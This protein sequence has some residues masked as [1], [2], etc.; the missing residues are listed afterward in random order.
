MKIFVVN[1]MTPHMHGGAEDLATYLIS[2]LRMAGHE[3]ELLRI[4]FRY[5][6]AECIYSEML[7]CRMMHIG[8]ADLVIALK[9]P[10][11]LIPH[12]KKVLWLV[13]QYRQAYDMWDSGYSNIPASETGH[14]LRSAIRE[15]D[16][17]CFHGVKHLYTISPVTQ[18][19]LKKY[20]NFESELLRT[21]IN[22]PEDYS[23]GDYGDYIFCGGRINLIKRQHL[24]V[25]AMRHVRSEA[26]LLIAGPADSP[27]DVHRLEAMV[28]QCG[29]RDR[30]IL[31]IG[32][33][34]RDKLVPMMCNSLACAYLPIDEDSYGYVT[35]EANQA[36]KG[37]LTVNDSGGLLDLVIDE[38][39]GW[40][41]SPD[42]REISEA[43]DLIFSNR[44]RSKEIGTH[45]RSEWLK[46]EITWERTVERLVA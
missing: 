8:D 9:F 35:M 20:N 14:K 33:H 34:D 45:A 41:R 28:E 10:A 12:P 21:P 26:K 17:E 2:H 7:A 42:P 5:E 29:L 39:T 6:P 13:H 1:N 30:V 46:K 23:P 15:A 16:E 43:I 22:G 3:A 32:Y 19:R 24:L 37:V 36:G 11:Y 27:Q 40:V 44:R 31:K 18:S 4:P 38:Q 25:E